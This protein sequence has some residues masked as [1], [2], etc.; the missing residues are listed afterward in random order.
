MAKLPKLQISKQ[1]P[2]LLST[3]DGDPYFMLGDTVWELFHRLSYEEAEYFLKTRSEQGFNMIWSTALAEFDGLKT[4][5]RY[6]LVP[7]KDLD[8][9]LPNVEYFAYVKKLIQLAGEHGLY[10]GLLPTWGDKVTQ[11]WGEGPVVF[12]T[13]NPGI[14]RQYGR[15]LGEL[16]RD[17]SNILWVLGGDR[18]ARK[19][20]NGEVVEDWTPVWTAMSE[21]ILEGYGEDALITYHPQ[22]GKDS[23]SVL[24]HDENW[25]HLNAMQSGHG[26][27]RDVQV[28][29]MIERD[30]AKV[31]PKPT[32]DSEPN[33]EDHPVSPWPTFDPRN[34]YFD[35]YDVRRQNY[36]S[37][38]AG[39]CGVI[40]GHHSIWQLAGE[41]KSWINHAKMDWRQAILRPGAV[42]MGYLRKLMEKFDFFSRVP[43]Q[44]VIVS[45]VGSGPF[46]K[47][48]IRSNVGTHIYVYLPVGGV[49]EVDVESLGT[50]LLSVSLFD[51]RTGI[52]ESVR[53]V[54]T[55]TILKT[56][57]LNDNDWVL[58]ICPIND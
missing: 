15:F 35:E 22:G 36:R 31:P 39:G 26:G 8:P 28:W 10:F 16:L 37:V 52:I 19:I 11:S 1:N 3:V 55:G 12:P 57:C 20:V 6:G 30:R 41:P 58:I 47:R 14:A 51:P 43:D 13:E 42:H 38:F 9:S 2:Y 54:I 29:E 23:T 34:G 27:G 25:L 56:E 46:H 33:Y 21:G 24:I 5:N 48:A 7:F 49:V 4:P 50:N 18:P 45:E 53:W 44:S 40:Y 32:F 17:E